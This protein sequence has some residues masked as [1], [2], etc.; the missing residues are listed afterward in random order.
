VSEFNVELI[1]LSLNNKHSKRGNSANALKR[2]IAISISDYQQ[3]VRRLSDKFTTYGN[4][5]LQLSGGAK[6][7]N[8][9]III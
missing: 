6:C 5:N 8:P 4:I 1:G 3:P 9:A 2:I 7:H